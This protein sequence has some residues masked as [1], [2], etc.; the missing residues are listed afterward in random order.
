MV[1]SLAILLHLILLLHHAMHKNIFLIIMC[2][3]QDIKPQS[4]AYVINRNFVTYYRERKL[5]CV[6][7]TMVMDRL[8]LQPQMAVPASIS[9]SFTVSG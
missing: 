9:Q 4:A 8:V 6:C 7:D 1:F 2:I 5:R 3:L